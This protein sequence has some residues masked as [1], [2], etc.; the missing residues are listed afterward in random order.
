MTTRQAIHTLIE[1]LEEGKLELA[2][3]ALEEIRDDGFDLTDEE[4]RALLEREAECARGDK[5]NVRDFL[6]ELRRE[7]L[8]DSNG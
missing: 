7:G 1:Q 2:R 8:A 3:Q 5:L 6:A 4:E